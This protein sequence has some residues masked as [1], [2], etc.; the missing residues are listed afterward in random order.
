MVLGGFLQKCCSRVNKPCWPKCISLSAKSVW[1]CAAG[2]VSWAFLRRCFVF[3]CGLELCGSVKAVST[4]LGLVVCVCVRR[5]D[6]SNHVWQMHSCA[7]NYLHTADTPLWSSPEQREREIKAE[8]EEEV[9]VK[10][11]S[12]LM[13]FDNDKPLFS[14]ALIEIPVCVGPVSHYCLDVLNSH[15]FKIYLLLT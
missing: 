5:L 1:A 14:D 12:L 13:T 6:P 3:V 9:V 8:K 10:L 15:S 2:S 11:K 4:L 7:C